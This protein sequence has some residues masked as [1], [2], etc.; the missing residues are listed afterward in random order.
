MDLPLQSVTNKMLSTNSSA[1]NRIVTSIIYCLNGWGKYL[2]SGREE[3]FSHTELLIPFKTEQLQKPP[4]P[5]HT[6]KK[7]ISQVISI[8][9][10]LKFNL[11]GLISN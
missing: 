10:L 8:G 2:H 9:S 6:H 1:S 4:A 5:P 3:T 7:S 11:L